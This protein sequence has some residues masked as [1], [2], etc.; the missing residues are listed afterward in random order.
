MVE[1]LLRKTPPLVG[2]RR[3]EVRSLSGLNFASVI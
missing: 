2:K 3:T 1:Q